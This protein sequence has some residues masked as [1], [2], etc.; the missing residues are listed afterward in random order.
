[1]IKTFDKFVPEWLHRRAH[2]QLLSPYVTW[3]FPGNGG[4]YGDIDKACFAKLLFDEER[5]YSDF[6]GVDSL[7]YVLECW[8]NQNN[9]WFKFERLNRC[10]L[11]FYTPGM[12]IGWHT[13]HSNP[14]YHT[15]IYYVNDSDG[16]TEFENIKVPH[17]ENSG[18]IL[19]SKDSHK[20]MESSVPR[21]ISV[22][23]ILVFD[24]TG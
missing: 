19:K 10:I 24:I 2:D 5:N 20:N 4:Y 23:W 15:L 16:G 13:D 1:M 12:T 7:V 21:R 9:N 11:N 8:L 17:K 22:A 6:S 18:V 14:R 3:H